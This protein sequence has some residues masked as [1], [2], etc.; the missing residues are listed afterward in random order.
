MNIAYRI[1]IFREKKMYSVFSALKSIGP[2][3]V[4]IHKIFKSIVFK[5]MTIHI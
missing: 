2:L 4:Y 5:N 1:C 3:T